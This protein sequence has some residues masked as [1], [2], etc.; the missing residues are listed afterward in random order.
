MN[1]RRVFAGVLLLAAMTGQ[2]THAADYPTK[3]VRLVV[4]YTAGGGSDVLARLLALKLSESLGQQ[5]IVENRPGAASTMAVEY[6]SKAAPDGYTLLLG[7]GGSLSVAPAIYKEIRYNTTKDFAPI[8]LVASLPI[9]MAVNKNGP[10]QSLPE[11]IDFAKRNPDK[12]SYSSPGSAFKLLG[13]Q[14]NLQA[15]T[16]LQE[17]PYKGSTDAVNALV[18]GDVLSAISD[19]ISTNLGLNTGKIKLVAISSAKEHPAFPGTPTFTEL[20]YKDM[21]I[22]LWQ[23]ILAPAGTSSAIVQRLNR[24]VARVLAMPDVKARYAAMGLDAVTS[25]PEDMASLMERDL[26]R[27]AETVRAANIPKQ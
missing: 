7:Q 26:A 19:S 3:P 22:T 15:G 17:I 21:D 23:G 18:A 25:T 5:V 11:L 16:H 27:S 8:S 12:A 1:A 6:V 24:E 14:L 9:L 4:G 13:E 2:A 20:G 10:A